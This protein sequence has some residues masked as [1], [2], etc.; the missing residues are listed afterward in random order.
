MHVG[1]TL[2][3]KEFSKLHN[4]LCELDQLA[5]TVSDIGHNNEGKLIESEVKAIRAVLTPAYDADSAK[6]NELSKMYADE[7]EAFSA[8]TIWSMYE[9]DNMRNNH[10]FEGALTVTHQTHFGEIIPVV[11]IQGKSWAALYCAAD[12]AIKQSGDMHHV[13]I[14]GFTQHGETLVL[15]TGS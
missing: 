1:V 2:T 11:A 10:S 9:V 13:F 8:A 6:F 7:G 5:E 15:H 14:E 4:A 3:P 12:A